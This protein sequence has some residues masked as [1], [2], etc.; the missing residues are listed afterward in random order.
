MKVY[1]KNI[2]AAL[3]LY[4]SKRWNNKKSIYYFL[5]WYTLKY[6]KLNLINNNLK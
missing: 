1:F 5:F 3:K 4:K 6:I 2:N